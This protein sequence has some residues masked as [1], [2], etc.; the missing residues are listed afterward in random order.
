MMIMMLLANLLVEK[1][2]EY[3]LIKDDGSPDDE[4]FAIPCR[5]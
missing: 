2:G 1:L 3:G 4:K 5:C